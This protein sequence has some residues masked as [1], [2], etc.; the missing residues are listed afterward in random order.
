MGIKEKKYTRFK[1]VQKEL[2]KGEMHL[3]IPYIEEMDNGKARL[4]ANLSINGNMQ[5]IYF[6]VDN[7]WKKYLVT[8]NSDA[9]ILAVLEKAMKNS[10]DISFEQPVSEEL[11]YGLVTYTIP[12]YARN[13]EMFNEIN[14]IGDITLE[15]PVSECKTGTGFSAGVDSFYTI[16]KHM[17]NKKT[18]S[19][20]VTHLLLA[21][22]GAA[23]TGVSEEMDREWLEASRE[24]FQKY[25]AAMGLELICAGGNIDLLY[26]NDTCLGGDA[27]TTSSFVYALQKLFSTY[28]WASTYP[29]NI[30]SFNQ[31]DG[32]FCE[33]VSVSYISTRKLKFYHSGSEINRIGKVK[34]IADNP[35]VQ[36]VLTVCG[37][38]DAFNCGCCFKC[39]RT[40]SELYAIKKLELFKDSFPADNYKKHFISK[41]AQEL[42]T[43]HP[44]FT[45]DI[46]NEMKNNRIKI[47]FIVYLLSFL[48]Y[49]PLYMLRSKLKHIVW[50]RRLFY[51][52]NLDEKILGRKQGSKERERKLNGIYKG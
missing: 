7:C 37:E 6:E 10:F 31:S 14:L 23:A 51:K 1:Y 32:G 42:S 20:N 25:A 15:N 4:C 43:D 45:T 41:F 19:Y 21:V 13:F 5:V 12:I 35:L 16:L 3:G 38:L 49:K 11:Y 48:V 17:G 46:I 2:K 22:N 52:F 44:P 24:K 39:L 8:E 18:P 28:Y 34:Y 47:P 33:N 9:F 29:A 26:L 36:K 40:M 50:L 30:F 27:I